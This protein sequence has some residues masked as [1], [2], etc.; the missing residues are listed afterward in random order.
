MNYENLAE[1]LFPNIDK[2]PQYYVEKYPARNLK[3]R[4]MCYKICT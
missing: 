4:S 2:T 3:R 1:L